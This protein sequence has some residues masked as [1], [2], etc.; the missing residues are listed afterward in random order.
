MGKAIQDLT[1]KLERLE[2]ESRKGGRST[3][4]KG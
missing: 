3:S 1:V 4:T 2:G